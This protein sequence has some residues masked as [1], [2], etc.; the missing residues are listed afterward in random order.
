M[1]M[2]IHNI[3]SFSPDLSCFLELARLGLVDRME[4]NP[5][6]LSVPEPRPLAFSPSRKEFTF[7]IGIC[8]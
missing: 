8:M 2:N 5:F 4:F 6:L 3:P 7:S 1:G